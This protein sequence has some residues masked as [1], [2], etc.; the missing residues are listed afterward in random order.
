ML[1][2]RRTKDVALI[3]SFIVFLT[4]LIVMAPAILFPPEVIH[5]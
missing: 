2:Q 3:V 5:G 1:M 4:A